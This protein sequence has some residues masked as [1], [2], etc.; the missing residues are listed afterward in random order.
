MVDRVQLVQVNRSQSNKVR[1]IDIFPQGY[2]LGPL[3]FT[4]YTKDVTAIIQQHIMIDFLIP[5][6]LCVGYLIG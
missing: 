6:T 3:L 4:F 5:A 2:M 1:L